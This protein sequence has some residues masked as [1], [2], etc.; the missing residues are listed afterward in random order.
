LSP[1]NRA[2]LSAS[3][4]CSVDGSRSIMEAPYA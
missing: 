2:M 1:R 4:S 3:C